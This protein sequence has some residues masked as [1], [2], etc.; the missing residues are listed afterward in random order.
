M[1]EPGKASD[2]AGQ[3]VTCYCCGLSFDAANMVAFDR[4][5]EDGV[6]VGCAAWLYGLS[7]P[8]VRRMYP[9]LGQLPARARACVALMRRVLAHGTLRHIAGP[10]AGTVGLIRRMVVGLFRD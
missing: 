1:T 10:P 4:R 5:P 2:Q 8:I 9:P 6:C 7:R 3:W